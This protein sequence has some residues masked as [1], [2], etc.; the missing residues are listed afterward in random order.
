MDVFDS[1]DSTDVGPWV[2]ALFESEC[3]SCCGPIML[4]DPIR[5]EDGEWVGECCGGNAE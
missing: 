5:A 1:V 4:G 3:A 2:A